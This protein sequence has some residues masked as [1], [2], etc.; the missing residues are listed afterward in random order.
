MS[1]K[2]LT[3]QQEQKKRLA[4]LLTEL[5]TASSQVLRNEYQWDDNQVDRFLEGVRLNYQAL[6]DGAGEFENLGNVAQRYGLAAG[7][8]L[9]QFFTPQ[10]VDRWLGLMIGRAKSN[11]EQAQK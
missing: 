7:N 3:P 5:E 8:Y 10:Q 4:V 11:R 9:K 1:N 6:P 2:K